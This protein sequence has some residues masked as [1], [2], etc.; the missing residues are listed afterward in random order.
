MPTVRIVPSSYSSSNSSYASVSSASNMYDNTDDTSNYA[1]LQGRNRNSST[2]YYIFING[3]DMSA[4]PDGS[5]VSS[6]EV[7]IRCYRNSNQRTGANYR[8]RLCSSP[9]S[10]SVIA[11]TTLSSDITTT[12]TVYSIP[13]GDLDWDTIKNCGTDFSIEVPLASTSSSRPYVYVYGAEIAVTYTEAT[14]YDVTSTLNGN[15]TIDPI[16]TTTLYAGSDYTLYI[17]PQNSGDSVTVTDN[18]VDVTGSLVQIQSGNDELVP[19]SYSNSGFTLTDITNAYTD[20]SD[21][22]RCTCDLAGGS[23][24]SLFLNLRQLDIPSSATIQSVSCEVS[25]EV[26]RNGSSSSMSANCQ[27]YSG[28]TSKGSSTTIVSS[29]SD[30]SRTTLTLNIGNWTASEIADARVNFQ[31]TNGASQ[32]HRYLYVYGV[33]FNVSYDISGTLY[34]Y[35]INDIQEDHTINVIISQGATSKWYYKVNGTW[36]RVSAIY[37]KQNGSWVGVAKMFTKANGNWEN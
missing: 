2:A 11:N 29:A 27:M 35:T 12:Q 17:E 13:I 28:D 14:P 21:S 4:V 19:D 37:Y 30:V 5:Q 8:L 26:S 16:G 22:N 23:T 31:M 18:G 32:T 20:I 10:S 24:G 33:S 34:S 9:S 36:R 3:F 7:K 25:I 15:G 1:T 6:I